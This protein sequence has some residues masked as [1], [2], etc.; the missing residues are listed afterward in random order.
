MALSEAI[1]PKL[2][3]GGFA[4]FFFYGIRIGKKFNR[5][6]AKKSDGGNA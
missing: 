5:L 3:R 2:H 1:D 4:A 6:T